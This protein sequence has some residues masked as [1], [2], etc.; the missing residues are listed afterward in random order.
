MKKLSVLGLA[1]ALGGCAGVSYIM[2]EYS[3]IERQTVQMPDDNYWVFDK[4]AA[5]KMMVTSSPGAAAAQ[6]FGS[7]LL[8][9]AVDNTPPKPL[10]EA[11]AITFL[12]QSGRASCRI[13]DAYL[14]VKPQYE[15]KYDC[16]PPPDPIA[17]VKRVPANA[18]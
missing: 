9:N 12:A 2:Q 4:P 3:G 18:R 5:N 7:G 14:L 6:G 11:A 10:F 17:A 16:T 8:L 15:V 1:L 13:V